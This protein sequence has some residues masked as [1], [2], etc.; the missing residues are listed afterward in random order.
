MKIHRIQPMNVNP[1]ERTARIEK[2]TK[3]TK[4]TDQV[5]ISSAAKELQEAAKF[6]SERLEKVERLK[7]EIESGTYKLDA[8]AVAESVLRYYKR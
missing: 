2:P 4:K 6:Y 1:Y 3:A 8:R 5:E 7:E